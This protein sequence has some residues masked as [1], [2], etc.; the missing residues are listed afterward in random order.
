[1]FSTES[2]VS[3]STYAHTNVS[4][5]VDKQLLKKNDDRTYLSVFVG[6]DKFQGSRD[7]LLPTEAFET[8]SRW[9]EVNSEML[10]RF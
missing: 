5:Y 3:V 1:M 2:K 8:Q 6:E 7:V 9:V 10:Q 4:L